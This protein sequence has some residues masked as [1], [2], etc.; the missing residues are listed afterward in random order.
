MNTDDF[1]PDTEPPV[2]VPQNWTEAMVTL[3]IMKERGD[4]NRQDL[5]A[6]R[7]DVAE[8]TK[9]L[10]VVGESMSE[11]RTT[12]KVTTWF[13]TK[14]AALGGVAGAAAASAAGHLWPSIHPK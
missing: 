10:K 11:A 4:R 12:L 14:L 9:Q 3:A 8:I 5:A 2:D 7:A 13:A 6:I 1:T